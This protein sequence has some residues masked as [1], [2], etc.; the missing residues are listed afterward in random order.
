MDLKLPLKCGHIAKCVDQ[1]PT[2]ASV[3]TS[4]TGTRGHVTGVA[5]QPHLRKINVSHLLTLKLSLT[6]C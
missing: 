6:S 2:V 5:Y 4:Q 1:S 3:H